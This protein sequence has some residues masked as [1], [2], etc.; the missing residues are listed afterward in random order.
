MKRDSGMSEGCVGI[1]MCGRMEA[2]S[3]GG[4]EGGRGDYRKG[5]Q[6]CCF[7]RSYLKPLDSPVI[8]RRRIQWRS[9]K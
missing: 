5:R 3:E 4:E 1:M 8:S 2:E 9:A 7:C 6:D